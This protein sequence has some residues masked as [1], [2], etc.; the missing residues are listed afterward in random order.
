MLGV[1]LRPAG[2]G[3]S[4]AD[5]VARLPDTGRSCIRRLA[6]QWINRLDVIKLNK[7]MSEYETLGGYNDV[8]EC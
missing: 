1:G 7:N 2:Q 6:T 8:G 3:V 4:V 5:S